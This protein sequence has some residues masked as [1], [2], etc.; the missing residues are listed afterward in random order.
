[1]PCGRRE[2][3]RRS[4]PPQEEKLASEFISYFSLTAG[5]QSKIQTQS[6]KKENDIPIVPSLYS[7][8][9]KAD[10]S[11]LAVRDIN[12]IYIVENKENSFYDRKMLHE[13]R[14]VIWIK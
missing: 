2:F 5:Y 9:N 4:D 8:S 14:I 6:P 7:L 12:H 11:L 13:I 3:Y 10:N 1:M